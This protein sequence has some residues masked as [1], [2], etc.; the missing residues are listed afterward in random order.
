M[1]EERENSALRPFLSRWRYWVLSAAAALLVL[2]AAAVAWL[3]SDMG[4]R[5]VA[6]RIATF[7]P[8]S[9]LRIQVGEIEG[10]IYKKAVLKDVRLYDPKG[11]FLSAPRVELDWWPLAW[12]SNRLDIDRLGIPTAT[13]HRMP[14]FR[15]APKKGPILPDFDIRLVDLNVG[16]LSVLPR[17]TGRSHVATLRGRV[18]VFSKRARVAL[19]GRVMGENDRLVLKLDSRP[20]DDRFDMEADIRAPKGGLLGSLAGLKKEAT[21]TIGGRGSWTRWNGRAE[22]LLGNAPL[23]DLTLEAVKGRYRLTGSLHPQLLRGGLIARMSTPEMAVNASGTLDKRLILGEASLRSKALLLEAK[24]GVDLARNMFDDL[25]LD[26]RLLRP[27]ALLKG[28]SGRNILLKLRVDGGFDAARFEYLLT[29]PEFALGSTRLIGMRAS[30]GGKVGRDRPTLIPLQIRAR[31]MLGN[32]PVVE[33]I[34][35]NVALDGVLQLKGQTL[36][37]NKMKLRAARLR[38]EVVLLTDLATGRY[39]VAL[40]GSIPGLLI[41]GLG[42]V[43]IRS[44]IRAAPGPSGAFMLMGRARADMRRFDNRFL[45]DVAGG[46]PRLTSTLSLD[47]DGILRLSGLQLNA[48]LI[49]L[50]ASGHRRK[51]G[52]FH[53][54]GLGSHG[55]YGSLKLTLDG[56]LDRPTVDLLLARPMDAAGLANAR[57]RL[58]PEASGFVFTA[59]GGSTLGPFNGNGRILLPKGGQALIQID[60]LTVSDT[61][62][63]GQIRPLA[64]GLDGR[65]EISGGGVSGFVELQPVSG[66]QRLRTQLDARNADFAGPPAFRARRGTLTASILLDPAGTSIDAALQARGLRRGTMRI[67]RVDA[68]ARLVGGRGTAKANLSGQRGRLFGLAVQAEIQPGRVAL[69]GGGT[70][71]RKPVRLIRPAVLTSKAEG[72]WALAP[73]TI[74]FAGGRSQFSGE[75]GGPSTRIEARLDRLPLSLLDIYN[76]ELGFGGVA[77][78]TLSY[79]RPRSAVPTG[80]AELRIRQLTRSGLAMSSQPV[81]VGVNAVLNPASAIARAIIV[82]D[83]KTVGRAQARLSPLSDGYFFDRLSNAPLFAQ[84][85]YNGPADTLWRLTNVETF[86]LSGPAAIGFDATGTLANPLIRGSVVTDNARLTSPVTGMVLTGIKTRGSF[87]GSRLVLSSF[88]G[89]SPGGGSVTGSG[90]FDLSATAGIG[91]DLK[92]QAENAVLLNRDDIGAT[93]TGPLAVRSDGSGGVISG[94]VQ[95]IRSRFLLGRASAVA[96]IPQLRIIEIN[97]RGDEDEDD[98]VRPSPWHLDIHANARNRLTVTGLGLDSEW[99]ADLQIGGTL[100][101]PTVLGTARLVRGEYEFAGRTFDLEKGE[102]RFTGNSPVNPNLDIA[103]SANITGLSATINVRGTGLQ[104]EISFSSVPALPED[105]LLSRLLFGSSITDLSAPE[106]LQLAAAVA[107]LQGGGGGLNPI[108]AV[109]KAAGLDRLRILPADS[110]TGQ[111]TSVAAGKY[112]TRRT[113]VELVTDG[114]GYS[115]TRIEF[116][117]TR[118][119]SLLSSISTMGRQSANVRISK[120]Y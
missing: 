33:G 66:V 13:L 103:A 39:N 117:I 94:D 53:L 62:A 90:S 96:E 59:S 21:V 31:R 15:P 57:V 48:P 4:H 49:R 34:F 115:A 76:E 101:N 80:R 109:R 27:S 113:Y 40:T 84:L 25:R 18:E 82:K 111:G 51:D 47:A 89:V 44:D 91:I 63:R 120:D 64:G 83:G 78:G 68:S 107:S 72:G 69:S 93:V 108:N 30:G 58:V 118:W 5:F 102:I 11:V 61:S 116:Q 29:A 42:I 9:G 60:H 32:G 55:R 46:L 20:D 28:S 37:S 45:R 16:R 81:D 75:L 38:S 23:A 3:D 71:D 67:G 98:Y 43:D 77:T 24:G 112:I 105:E 99:R 70:L 54:V 119:L 110:V 17:V 56:R 86:D 88:S 10:S 106:A 100:T 65:L 2:L 35:A 87:D 97:R 50:S 95:L 36:T 114:Q 79:S 6:E 104:P 12:L 19:Y 92:L 41:P 7:A 85:R 1:S 8:R 74:T 73:A 26:A 14:K 52:S 22:A